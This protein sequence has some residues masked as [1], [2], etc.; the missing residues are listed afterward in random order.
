[1]MESS[2]S[3]AR[4]GKT[5]PSSDHPT[6]STTASTHQA[7]KLDEL[8]VDWPHRDN[9]YP[10]HSLETIHREKTKAKKKVRF[11]ESSE[12][13]VYWINQECHFDHDVSKSNTNTE[14]FD[15]KLQSNSYKSQKATEDSNELFSMYSRPQRSSTHGKIPRVKRSSSS[16]RAA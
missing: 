6:Q 2:L 16:A 7:Q 1:M 8:I 11:S 3:L 15:R 13:R 14:V 10:S 5:N 9:D 4:F 12:V